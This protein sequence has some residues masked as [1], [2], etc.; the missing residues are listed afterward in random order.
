MPGT[1]AIDAFPET[2]AIGALPGTFA[3]G[4][5]PGT[6]ATA[7]LPGTF[8]IAAFPGTFAIGAFPG[9]FAMGALPGTSAIFSEAKAPFAPAICDDLPLGTG[10]FCAALLKVGSESRGG[11]RL[12][13]GAAASEEDFDGTAPGKVARGDKTLP[14]GGLGLTNRKESGGGPICP[15]GLGGGDAGVGGGKPRLNS[16]GPP[17]AAGGPGNGTPGR[18]NGGAAFN[19]GASGGMPQLTWPNSPQRIQCADVNGTIAFDAKVGQLTG[20]CPLHLQWVHIDDLSGQSR[21]SW[22]CCPQKKQ[23]FK[24][25]SLES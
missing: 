10:A 16:I 1:F 3:I 22:P 25:Q 13:L 9:T 24:E 18:W 7:A 19:C 8:A 17:F 21:P 6:A 15:N 2:F 14:F 20:M 5:L 4:A 23:H 12:R 11:L